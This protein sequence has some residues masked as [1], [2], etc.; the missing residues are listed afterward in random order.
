LRYGTFEAD[1]RC[2][3]HVLLLE[4]VERELLIVEIRQ[5]ARLHAHEGVPRPPGR[6][7]PEEAAALHRREDRG[8]RVVQPPA[9][10]TSSR[11]L[12]W[13]PSAVCTAHCASTLL[14]RRSDASSLQRVQIFGAA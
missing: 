10:A 8:A 1:A 4:Q 11:M 9:R 7:E 5:R 12:W 13:P 3:Q 6:G 2:D 14:H